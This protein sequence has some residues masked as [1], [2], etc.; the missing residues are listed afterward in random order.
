[1]ERL[2]SID[3]LKKLG[4]SAAEQPALLRELPRCSLQWKKRQAN[5]ELILTSLKPAARAFAKRG[6]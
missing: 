5:A 6:L 2:K 1:M 3:D 4:E